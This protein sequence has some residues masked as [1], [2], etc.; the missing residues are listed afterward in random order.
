MCEQK[1]CPLSPHGNSKCC[2]A[3]LVAIPDMGLRLECAGCGKEV[4]TKTLMPHES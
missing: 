1:K 3:Q 2:D 4:N